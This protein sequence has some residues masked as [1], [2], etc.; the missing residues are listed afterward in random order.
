[1]KYCLFALIAFLGLH[2]QAQSVSCPNANADGK[3]YEVILTF[4]GENPYLKPNT[5]A[6]Y[7]YNEGQLSA[8][9][10]C[11]MHPTPPGLGIV[12][13]GAPGS[14]IR[15]VQGSEQLP[16]PIEKAYVF[17]FNRSRIAEGNPKSTTVRALLASL[18]PSFECTDNK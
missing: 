8:Q 9:Y 2:A 12:V 1:M 15:S 13:C 6:I 7:I 17:D 18:Q 10:P 3:V 16:S 14:Q 5:A 11:S 4:T